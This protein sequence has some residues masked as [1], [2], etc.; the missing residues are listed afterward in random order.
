MDARI[1]GLLAAGALLAGSLLPAA[2]QEAGPYRLERTEDGYVRMDTRT[3]RMWLC[4]EDGAD[5]T[6]TAAAEAGTDA[7]DATLADLEA[8][9][10]ALEARLDAQTPGGELPSEEEFERSLTLMERFMHRFMGIVRDFEDETPPSR[11]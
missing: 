10:A 3:G 2:A 4:R 9:I 7:P 6:C 5:L 8:R 11:L 1:V